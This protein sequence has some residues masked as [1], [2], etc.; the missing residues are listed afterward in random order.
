M[1]AFRAMPDKL[2]A[3]GVTPNS[4]TVVMVGATPEPL[5]SAVLQ[6][7]EA[8]IVAVAVLNMFCAVAGFEQ[9]SAAQRQR[10]RIM[11]LFFM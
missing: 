8:L 3:V 9:S 6:S 7:V 4:P 2:P 5:P 1:L 11:I 10:E